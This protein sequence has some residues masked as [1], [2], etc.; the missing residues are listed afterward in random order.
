MWGQKLKIVN[1]IP[2]FRHRLKD[3]DGNNL[4]ISVNQNIE[5]GKLTNISVSFPNETDHDK[6]DQLASWTLACKL[7]SRS[8]V[9]GIDLKDLTEDL[10]K[11]AVYP[12]DIPSQ[13]LKVL[14]SY[15]TC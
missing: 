11:S 14:N 9:N 3:I 12:T 1:A 13:M 6:R 2:C 7:V 5:T 4:Y 15:L 8:L 10:E